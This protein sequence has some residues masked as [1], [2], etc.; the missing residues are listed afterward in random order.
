MPQP[1]LFAM[2]LVAVA[3]AAIALQSPIN[4]ALGRHI[5][6][7]LG[8]ATISFGVGFVL[9]VTVT[10]A[11]G[12]GGK[13]LGAAQAPRLLLT[14]GILGAFLVWATLY[15][16]PVLGVLTLTAV[17]ILGQITAALVIDHIGIFGLAAREISLPRILAALMVAGGVVLSRY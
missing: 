12:D 3:G 6:S 17:L 4:S 15:S 10:L 14:G 8:A 13:L 5:S 16:V 9:L 11:Y 1:P 2:I 7:S